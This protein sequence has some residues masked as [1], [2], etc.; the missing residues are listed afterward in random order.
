MIGTMASLARME[1]EIREIRERN[2]KVE[3]DKTWEESRARKALVFLLTYFA[4][5]VFFLFAKLPDPFVNALVPALAF[6]LSG[7]T[8][9][10]FKKIWL[11]H[12][13]VK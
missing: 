1:K 6:A 13:Y 12:F 7:M 8:L 9:P 10:F 4:V 11:T 3:A 2:K 5:A